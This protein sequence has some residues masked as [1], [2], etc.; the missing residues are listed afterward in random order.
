[1]EFLTYEI[2][3]TCMVIQ[4]DCSMMLS[5]LALYLILWFSQIGTCFDSITVDNSQGAC[6]VDGFPKTL[7]M[8]FQITWTYN[9]NT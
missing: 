7:S 3:M 2:L 4:S 8:T 9:V 6:L 1:M 5:I